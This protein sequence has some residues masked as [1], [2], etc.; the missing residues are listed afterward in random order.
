MNNPEIVDL[1]SG[2]QEGGELPY[3]V[4]KQYGSGWLKTIGRFALPL[5]RRIGRIGMKTA[6]DVIMNNAKILPTL[7]AN[8]ISG[9][10]DVIPKVTGMF[11]NERNVRKRKIN[12]RDSNINKRY[13]GNGTIFEK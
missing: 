12:E 11:D 3:F 1:Y 10:A 8:A 5:L 9:L 6:K 13:K 4:G 7:K 2:S